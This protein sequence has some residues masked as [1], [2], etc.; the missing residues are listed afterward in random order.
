MS[1]SHA[2]PASPVIQA[3]PIV[4]GP[5]A[6]DPSID[7]PP[8]PI[9]DQ[10]NP[11]LSLWLH[12]KRAMRWIL[13][14]RRPSQSM[15]ILLIAC[16]FMAVE[17]IADFD[18]SDQLSLPAIIATVTL[19][20]LLF[21]GTLYFVFGWLLHRMAVAW[22]GRASLAQTRVT[23]CWTSLFSALASLATVSG[24]MLTFGRAYF[25]PAKT[26]MVDAD[27]SLIAP[28]LATVGISSLIMIVG[29]VCSV[30][31][32]AEAHRFAWWRSLLANLFAGFI[33]S[34][35]LLLCL[36]VVAVVR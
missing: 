8:T 17:S 35:I 36:V 29:A 18:K 25:S 7:R 16:L 5:V 11:W 32:L 4:Q 3:P 20:A 1:E 21:F 15:P 30:A 19:L 13:E 6:T 26:D 27:P 28:Y 14:H 10:L 22:K 2:H 31:M 34:V 12:P 9:P 24:G 33:L 23:L